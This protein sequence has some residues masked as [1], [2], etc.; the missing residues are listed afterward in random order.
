MRHDICTSKTAAEGHIVTPIKAATENHIGV[1]GTAAVA[2]ESCRA[3]AA[4]FNPC[5]AG[6]HNFCRD[7]RRRTPVRLGRR[8]TTLLRPVVSALS[9]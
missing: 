5:A 1:R 9:R 6:L 3:P 8:G 4:A 2:R 7:G